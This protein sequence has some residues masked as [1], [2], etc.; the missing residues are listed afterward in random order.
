MKKALWFGVTVVA[1]YACSEPV[2]QMLVDAGEMMQPDPGAQ[3]T[4][5]CDQTHTVTNVKGSRTEYLYAVVTVGNPRNVSVEQ[6]WTES[7]TPSFP[8]N[9]RCNVIRFTWFDGNDGYIP[10]GSKS[11]DAD[12]KLLGESPGPVSIKVYE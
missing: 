9:V 1:V 10:C 7:P 6:C 12:G 8:P 2:G 5:Q 11:F 3:T 4:A